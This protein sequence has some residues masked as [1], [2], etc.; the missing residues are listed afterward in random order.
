MLQY[1]D[2]TNRFYITADA[3]TREALNGTNVALNLVVYVTQNL[4]VSVEYVDAEGE[5]RTVEI[6]CDRKKQWTTVSLVLENVALNGSLEGG[7]DIYVFCDGPEITRLHAVYLSDAKTVASPETGLIHSKFET[8]FNIIADANVISFGATGNG[9]T[10]DT[11]AFKEAISFVTKQGGG[12]V[13][14]PAGYYCLTE[15]LNLPTNVA[16]VGELEM[17]TANG[18]VLCIYGGK[19]STDPS[20]SAIILR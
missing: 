6:P 7:N 1:W 5:T 10:D 15:T 19:G 20:Q 17:G 2:K 11:A 13:F 18:T 9:L 12:T 14:V 4:E 3:A 8:S 16:L